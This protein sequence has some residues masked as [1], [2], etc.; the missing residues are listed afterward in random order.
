MTMFPQNRLGEMMSMTNVQL[1]NDGDRETAIE[2]IL[3]FFDIII[4]ISWFKFGGTR[5]L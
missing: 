1:F 5:P 2:E 3:K 4:L